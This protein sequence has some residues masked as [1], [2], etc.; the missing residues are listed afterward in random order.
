[1]PEMRFRLIARVWRKFAAQSRA[2]KLLLAEAALCLTTARGIL[3]L[4][5]FSRIAKLLGGIRAPDTI[6]A[7]KLQSSC[8]L[9]AARDISWAIDRSALISPVALVCLPRALAAWA[10]LRRRGIAG[11]LH[12]GASCDAAGKLTPH[13]WCDSPGVEI[14]GYPEA[15]ECMEIGFFTTTIDT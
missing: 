1:M 11:R 12:F 2:R 4:L 13:A 5:P 7:R 14:T 15:H 9:S 6:F 3:F 10:M 8:D